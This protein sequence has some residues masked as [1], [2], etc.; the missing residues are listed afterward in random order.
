M[1]RLFRFF[2]L[3]LFLLLLPLVSG[4]QGRQ[5]RA[6]TDNDQFATW[7]HRGEKELSNGNI[8]SAE[9][10]Y[11]K[12]HTLALKLN[13]RRK[14][15]EYISDYVRLLNN[16][17]KYQQ[18]LGL[19]KELLT[20]GRA[21]KDTTI[22]ANAYGSIGNQ[23]IYLGSFKEAAK[24]TVTALNLARHHGLLK[25]QQVYS[26]NLASIF[27]ELRDKQKSSFYSRISYDIAIRRKDSAGIASSLVNIANSETISRRFDKAIYYYQKLIQLGFQLKD[28]SYVLDGYINMANVSSETKDY[29][30]ARQYYL[31]A[32]GLLKRYPSND[33]ELYVYWGLAESSHFLGDN[34]AAE[35]YLKKSIALGRRSGSSNQ[36]KMMYLLASEIFEKQHKS[37]AALAYRKKHDVLKDSISSAETQA[38]V[39]KLEI[40]YQTVEKEK[41]LAQQQLTIARNRIVIQEKNRLITLYLVAIFFLVSL[42]SCIYLS[43]SQ[44]RKAQQ[45]R[46]KLM[47]KEKEVQT[48]EAMIA[49]EEK[50]RARLA[51]ELHD[52]V[53]GSLSAAKMHLSL[54][55]SEYNTLSASDTYNQ[56]L[57]IIDTVGGEIR[58]I[59][60]N[61]AP[62]FLQEKGLIT[63]LESFCRKVSNTALKVEF[64]A[65]GAQTVQNLNF[66]LFIYRIVQECI[67]NIIKHA[68]ATSAI[69][70]IS[71]NDGVLALTIEDDGI[72]F[73][74][75]KLEEKGLGLGNLK[76]RVEIM[77]GFF[78]ISSRPLNGTAIYLE[79][80]CSAYLKGKPRNN[81]PEP[82]LQEKH[83]IYG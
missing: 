3:H 58:S 34:V 27:I 30:R 59:A 8:D 45:Q 39:N 83:L 6:T 54:L 41:R 11:N 63:T 18:A 25:M 75:T 82:K 80:D 47:E 20:I 17:S 2:Y 22:I 66:E 32:F 36:L 70:Q 56:T 71:I 35:K 15:A 74:M 4:A 53:G 14:I 51:K 29:A 7:L 81:K 55:G 28:L 72:G 10:W 33:Y 65:L 24:H 61:L 64:Y 50:E 5:P 68:H 60:H 13:D 9:F 42:L 49:G 37:E 48:L 23:Y 78:E 69:V 16:Q 79:F 52:G 12:A 38:A 19:A 76:S 57:S 21:L 1:H 77:G 31:K 40:E 67:N 46:L 44:K 73:D 43:F 26:N 62:T